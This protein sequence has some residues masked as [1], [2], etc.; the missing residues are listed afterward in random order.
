M[1]HCL[2]PALDHATNIH[3]G[4]RQAL[5]F[6]LSNG[7]AKTDALQ[8]AIRPLNLYELLWALVLRLYTGNDHIAFRTQ[9]DGGHDGPLTGSGFICSAEISKS[10]TI[11][12]IVFRHEYVSSAKES[13]PCE[14]ASLLNTKLLY[15]RSS[16]VGVCAGEETKGSDYLTER[17][18]KGIQSFLGLPR[19]YH[20]RLAVVFSQWRRELVL[21]V[22]FQSSNY[23]KQSI[24]N[25]GNT[26]HTV[27]QSLLRSPTQT[28]GEIRSLSS[29][30][31][32][33]I[34]AW[35]RGPRPVVESTIHEKISRHVRIRPDAPALNA[36][37]GSL[38]Y[39]QLDL[40]SGNVKA[41]LHDLG[42]RIGEF[43]P[44][45]FEKSQW[46]A[47]AMLAIL[48]AGNIHI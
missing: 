46:A 43:V 23:S 17:T 25:V 3:P 22:H 26:C 36:W 40:V 27:F 14:T 13:S 48:K 47:V 1:E 7:R 41:H 44:A 31:L 10:Q 21:E 2:F 29:R 24:L 38:T 18:R 35:N 39:T 32:N 20:N 19:A 9:S 5:T 42:M 15:D 45:Y 33:R 16:P 12:S 30:D 37:D 4:K 11:P 8:E 28:I 6:S 34:I